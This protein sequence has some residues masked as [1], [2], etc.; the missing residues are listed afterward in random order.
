[1]KLTLRQ[2][3]RLNE[4]SIKKAAEL[5]DVSTDSIVRW[6][7]GETYPNALQVAE[8]CRVYKWKFEDIEWDVTK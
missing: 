4:I 7:R 3:R 1:M 2:L 5:L 8:I 6:E